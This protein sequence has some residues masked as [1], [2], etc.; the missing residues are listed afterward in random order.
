MNPSLIYPGIYRIR[1]P[2][3]GKKPGPV[4][5]YLFKGKD[6]ITLL[7]TGTDLSWRYLE[8]HLKK[9][10]VCFSHIHRIIMTHGHVDHYGAASRIFFN[11]KRNATVI[12]HAADRRPIETGTDVPSDAYRRFLVA[13]GT[14]VIY[15]FGIVPMFFLFRK[16]LARPCPVHETLNLSEPL[17][18]GDYRA[19]VIETPGHTRGSVCLL[20]EKEGILF[21]G[22]HILPHITPNAFPMLE[23]SGLPV[24]SSQNEFYESLER[25]KIIA[26]QI[27]YPAHGKMIRDFESVHNMYKTCF[28]Q[29]QDSILR[30]VQNNPGKSIYDMAR[31]HFPEISGSRRFILDLYLAV[32][33]VYTHIQVLEKLGR[34]RTLF[35]NRILLVEY[36]Q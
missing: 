23:K 7:D 25:I 13:T 17:L 22:D 12:A 18:M 24:R 15:H 6:N 14:P 35:T 34:V 21:S 4:N 28:A 10:G 31:I 9:I 1:L 3:A 32:S 27:I 20:L 16:R 11:G 36:I 5:V 33:E 26:P 19:K 8:S 2:L 30:T 29:R